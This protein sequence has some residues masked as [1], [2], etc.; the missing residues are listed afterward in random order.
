MLIRLCGVAALGSGLICVDA[1]STANAA[2]YTFDP[3]LASPSR[4][5]A[6]ATSPERSRSTLP[7]VSPATT[8]SLREA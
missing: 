6:L 1:I 4:T 7:V 8:W 3:A 2:T 5:A